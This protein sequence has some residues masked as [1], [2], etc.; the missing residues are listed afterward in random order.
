MFNGSL[1]LSHYQLI[2]FPP[3]TIKSIPVMW[4][5]SSDAKKR[6]ALAAS[7]AFPKRFI[8]VGQKIEVA[9]ISFQGL[10]C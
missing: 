6:M 3:S 2:D 5:L 1:R 10:R 4:L 8:G 7:S 9:L